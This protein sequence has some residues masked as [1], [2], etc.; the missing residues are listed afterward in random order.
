[1]ATTFELTTSGGVITT[2]DQSMTVEITQTSVDLTFSEHINIGQKTGGS[3][4]I[5]FTAADLAGGVLAIGT[6]QP[7]VRVDRVAVVIDE[8][9]D[10]GTQLT[11]GDAEA[12]A[13]LM[14]AAENDP[15]VAG[16]YTADVDHEYSAETT[17]NLY[18]AAGTP[19]TGSGQ[20]IIYL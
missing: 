10:G 20:V 1:M 8:A 5:S 18:L 3:I 12:Q 13:R 9:F 14:A 7:G 2:A 15:G 17:I 19:V 4:G 16:K 11:V 6:V